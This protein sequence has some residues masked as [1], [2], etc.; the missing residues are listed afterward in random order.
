MGRRRTANDRRR[1]S[2]MCI[3]TGWSRGVEIGANSQNPCSNGGCAMW[4]AMLLVL[5]VMVAPAGGAGKGVKLEQCRGCRAL[6]VVETGP[7]TFE[8]TLLP[9][10]AGIPFQSF[11]FTLKGSLGLRAVATIVNAGKSSAPEVWPFAIPVA[12]GDGGRSWYRLSSAEYRAGEYRIEVTMTSPEVVVSYAPLYGNERWL[13]LLDTLMR[14]RLL[15]RVDT[16]VAEDGRVPVLVGVVGERSENAR[17]VVWLL[18]RQHAGEA[19]G[20]WVLQGFLRWLLAGN[21][22]VRTLLQRAVVYI[23]GVVNAEGVELG[24]YRTDGRGHDIADDWVDGPVEGSSVVAA[25]RELV[26]ESSSSGRLAALV[27]LHAHS[28]ERRN[29]ALIPVAPVG[30]YERASRTVALLDSLTGNVSRRLSTLTDLRP[31]GLAAGWVVNRFGANAFVLEV[32]YQDLATMD[33]CGEYVSTAQL[34]EIGAALGEAIVATEFG[35]RSGAIR[36]AAMPLR[37]EIRACRQ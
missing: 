34:E 21:E 22:S 37:G 6:Q 2:A 30:S 31:T 9:E 23:V 11:A 24:N 18:A 36:G 20:S 33:R 5:A 15:I 14:R 12:S 35:G 27:D 17:A 19:G 25:L 1:P 16:L 3:I 10:A 26:V 8:L 13:A 7:N 29:F 28:S 32:A 4:R